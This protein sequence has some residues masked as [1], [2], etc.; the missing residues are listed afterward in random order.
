MIAE[1]EAERVF[2]APIVTAVERM[3]PF[4]P[5]EE[6]H[7]E[8]FARNPQQ[9]YCAFVIAP[10]VAKLRERFAHRLKS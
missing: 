9:P 1:L 5:A 6:G 2:E 8:F 4:W 10:K 7:Q 3:G